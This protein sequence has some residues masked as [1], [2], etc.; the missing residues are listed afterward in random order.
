ML[1][2]CTLIKTASSAAPQIPLSLRMLG[3]N[4]G[5]LRPLALT[6]RHSNHSDRSHLGIA[7]LHVM[8]PQPYGFP[9]CFL[10]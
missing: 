2:F 6:V 1:S 3:A 10:W 4:P 9:L 8:V 7:V 5:L